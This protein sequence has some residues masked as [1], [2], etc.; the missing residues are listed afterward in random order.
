MIAHVAVVSCLHGQTGASPS[1]VDA[2]D[3]TYVPG[4]LGGVTPEPSR[5][6]LSGIGRLRRDARLD[7]MYLVLLLDSLDRTMQARMRRNLALVPSDWMPTKSDR[8]AREAELRRAMDMDFV[9]PHAYIP[10]FGV[11]TGAVF[12]ALGLVED[13]TPRITYT[14]TSTQLV[15]V[16]VYNL[17]AEL[18]AVIVDGSQRPGVYDFEWDLR[19]MDG[20]R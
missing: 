12:R 10:L 3:S 9:F 2:P 20:K 15:T 16:K 6:S 8:D 19:D 17:E 11:S 1:R 14:L 4:S 5:D 13:V 7:S 18:I